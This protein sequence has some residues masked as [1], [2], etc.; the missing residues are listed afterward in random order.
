MIKS[1]TV[2]NK[3]AVEFVNGLTIEQ[4]DC[5]KGNKLVVFASKSVVEYATTFV[6]MLTDK[7]FD[8]YTYLTSDG[9]DNKNLNKAVTFTQY[10]AINGIGRKDIIINIGGGTLCDLGAFV[11]SIYMRGISFVNIPTTLLCA[12]DACMGG[13]TAID[14]AGEK[15]LWGTFYQPTKI[16]IDFSL[17]EKLPKSRIAKA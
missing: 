14:V 5:F 11:A 2:K 16:I 15:N 17:L 9:E 13:K 1:I 10:L 12:V 3:C 8:T 7:G 6:K 4:F